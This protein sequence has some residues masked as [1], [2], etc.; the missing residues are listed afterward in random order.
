MTVR[1]AIAGI[2]GRMGN[3]ITETVLA[4][5]DMQL[6]AG[7]DLQ[8][9]R[10]VDKITV[11]PSADM[12]RVLKATKPDV[13]IDFTIASAA[14]QNAKTASANGVN[15]IIGTTGFDEAQK[16]EDEKGL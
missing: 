3:M 12:D 7:F 15:L 2:N 9:G 5:P 6:V 11:S 1:I 13:L 14:V 8:G 10:A 16:A 4:Q